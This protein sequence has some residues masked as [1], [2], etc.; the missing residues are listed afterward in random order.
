MSI[1]H[2]HLAAFV[3]ARPTATDHALREYL[4]FHHGATRES[5]RVAVDT[6][7]AQ[8]GSPVADVGVGA[9]GGV[10]SLDQVRAKF[11]ETFGGATPVAPPAVPTPASYHAM[12][13]GYAEL[14]AEYGRLE[15]EWS[16]K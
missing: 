13:T 14:E 4:V 11:D 2:T 3:G 5:A 15:A 9:L 6:Y 1:Y 12:A 8:Y 10:P 16:N 7:R